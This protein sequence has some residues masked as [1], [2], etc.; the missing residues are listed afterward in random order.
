MMQQ[1]IDVAWLG[2]E[3]PDLADSSKYHEFMLGSL[4]QRALVEEEYEELT[5]YINE[6]KRRIAEHEL[7]HILFIELCDS[8]YFLKFFHPTCFWTGRPDDE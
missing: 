8:P 5:V 4:M 3:E 1:Q 6:I 2:G 7:N